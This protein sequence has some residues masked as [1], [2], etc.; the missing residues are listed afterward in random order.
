MKTR[1]LC[2]ATVFYMI[3]IIMGLYIQKYIVFLLCIT[4]IILLYICKKIRYV[5]LIFVLMLGFISIRRRKLSYQG[6]SGI[7]NRIKGV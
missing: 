2:I 3:G 4:I 5:I 6:S 1:P 7:R